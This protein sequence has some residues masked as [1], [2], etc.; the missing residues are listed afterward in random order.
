MSNSK[1]IDFVNNLKHSNQ[2]VHY[3]VDGKGLNVGTVQ[4]ILHNSYQTKKAKNIE[5]YE[6]D[7]HLSGN[8]F[9]AYYNKEK[10]HL[11]TAHTGS[12]STNDWIT[13]A[14][15][16]LFND[17]SSNRFKHA[18]DMQKKAEQKY[19][20]NNVTI[21][22]HSLGKQLAQEANKNNHELITVNGATTAYDIGKNKN[23]NEYNIRTTYD[24][25]SV[26]ENL[27]PKNGNELNIPSKTL[28]PLTEHHTSVLN[29]LDANQVIGK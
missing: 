17:K 23:K 2:D 28:N 27:K 21:V 4:N 13:N 19:K 26:L 29:R 8:R 12:N 11:V 20:T 18:K 10:N 16:G 5:G 15:Y 3:F 25:P 14:R 1:L 24:V 22:A 6:L 9:Q 7:P